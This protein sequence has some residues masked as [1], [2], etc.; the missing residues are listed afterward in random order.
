MGLLDL[1][2]DK[3]ETH[4]KHLEKQFDLL[5]R[6][7]SH[8]GK[9]TFA[10]KFLKDLQWPY[11]CFCME[12]LYMLA[13]IDFDHKKMT[14]EIVALIRGYSR[15]WLSSLINEDGFNHLRG[16][17]LNHSAGQMGREAK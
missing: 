15:Y 6:L 10:Q 4:M 2:V 16:Q 11:H 17:A 7:E 3:R 1:A 13:E 14:E 8:A 5:L 12:I 9:C